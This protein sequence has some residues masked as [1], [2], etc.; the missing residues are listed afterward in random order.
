[1]KTPVKLIFIALPVMMVAAVSWHLQHPSQMIPGEAP[2]PSLLVTQSGTVVTSQ[3]TYAD[4]GSCERPR[5]DAQNGAVG[6]RVTEIHLVQFDGDRPQWTL[7][8][9]SAHNSG[10]EHILIHKPDLT[11]FK[12]DGQR[13]SVTSVEGFVDNRSQAMVFTGD[14]VATNDGQKLSTEIL[15]FDPTTQILYTD[16]KFSLVSREMELEGIGLTLYQATRRLVVDHRVKVHYF[17]SQE[18]TI[19]ENANPEHS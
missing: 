8:A 1:M 5:S 19:R 16:Q 18:E 14:V 2:C 12:K 11:L 10:E 9:P 7:I 13:A 15:R 3:P 4:D 6:T 17:P